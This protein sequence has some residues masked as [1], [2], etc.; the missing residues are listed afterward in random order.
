MHNVKSLTFLKSFSGSIQSLTPDHPQSTCHVS[1]SHHHHHNAYSHSSSRHRDWR[2][3]TR[4]FNSDTTGRVGWGW[5]THS[6]MLFPSFEIAIKADLIKPVCIIE[7]F[8][9]MLTGSR[10]SHS[11]EMSHQKHREFWDTGGVMAET[12]AKDV[13][14]TLTA[15]VSWCC[16]NACRKQS[17]MY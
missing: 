3:R 11:V 5:Q 12:F 15:C 8:R 2:N 1:P 6:F 14:Q 13:N 7:A 4:H 9:E 16:L 10:Y 17:C